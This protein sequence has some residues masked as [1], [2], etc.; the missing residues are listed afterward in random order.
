M[1]LP[2]TEKFLWDIF[3]IGEGIA[4]F[5]TESSRPSLRK[6]LYP[7]Y[8]EIQKMYRKKRKIR[9]FSRLISYLKTKGYI[10]IKEI[11]NKEAIILTPRGLRKLIKVK[12]KLNRKRRKDGRWQ[13]IFYDIPECKRKI[14]D[15][16]RYSLQAFG[17]QRFQQSIWVSPYDVT[18]ETQELI[19]EL[20]LTPYARLL[21]VKEVEI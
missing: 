13:M 12:C 18:K 3:N 11:E 9:E 14:R 4:E 2:F 20:N 10:K 15:L 7:E 17:Y 8:A 1:K 5:L 16:F 6:A 21:L 19:R